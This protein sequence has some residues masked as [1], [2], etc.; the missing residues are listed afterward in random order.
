M[1]RSYPLTP[2]IFKHVYEVQG[3]KFDTE[4]RNA[5]YDM[6]FRYTCELFNRNVTNTRLKAVGLFVH[7][8]KIP[9]DDQMLYKMI[10]SVDHN[11]LW[12]NME[13]MDKF[14]ERLIFYNLYYDIGQKKV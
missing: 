1:A 9:V 3:E 5:V 8:V 4:A 13:F 2:S 11:L 14:R 10:R 12:T 6:M 7:T